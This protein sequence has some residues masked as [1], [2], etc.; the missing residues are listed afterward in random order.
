MDWTYFMNFINVETGL[1]V[2]EGTL[3]LSL[4]ITLVSMRR[5]LPRSAAKESPLLD[6]DQIREWARESETICQGLSKNLEE[7]KVIVRRLIA[8]L[9]EKIRTFE[10]LLK[11]G[12]GK[13]GRLSH[14]GEER[15]LG[16]QVCDLVRTGCD[17]SEISRRLHLSK[18]EVELILDLKRYRP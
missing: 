5:I 6:S 11:E 14:D 17:V 13:G 12:E 7:K 3:L 4:L 16:D 10:I 15:D 18:G 2:I 9:D 8:Q 1:I